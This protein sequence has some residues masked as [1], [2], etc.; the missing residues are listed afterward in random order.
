MT[1]NAMKLFPP[2]PFPP[3]ARN[4]DDFADLADMLVIVSL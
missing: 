3:F 1:S 2:D 4:P